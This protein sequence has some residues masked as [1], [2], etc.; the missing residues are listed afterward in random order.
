[1]TT[2]HSRSRGRGRPR[3][4]DPV[5]VDD[6]IMATF[7]RKGYGATTLDDL[8]DATG[9]NRPSLYKVIGSKEEAYLSAVDRYVTEY[10]ARYVA[11]LTAGRSFAQD[12]T[13][14]YKTYVKTVS[15]EYG[16]GCPVGC[17]VPVD[18]ETLPRLK[19]ILAQAIGE[20]DVIAASRA[21]QAAAAGELNAAL[22]ASEAGRL[23]V[24]TLL[25]LS[26]RSRA[27]ERPATLRRSANTVIRLVTAAG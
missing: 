20:L 23:I 4:F 13:A 7:W 22:S 18:T 9:L 19:E 17:T 14:F 25:S 5:A 1:M 26:I 2:L 21:K 27:G 24:S 15:S 11:A 8:S 6:A 10:G 3:A 16:P 12:L